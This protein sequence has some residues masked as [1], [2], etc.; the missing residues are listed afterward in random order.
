MD[1]A[2]ELV[3]IAALGRLAGVDAVPVAPIARRGR[4]GRGGAAMWRQRRFGF[5][6]VNALSRRRCC[7][8][9]PFANVWTLA[10]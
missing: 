7:H 2:K 5:V 8:R 9:V 1:D 6:A 10:R 4:R 3:A